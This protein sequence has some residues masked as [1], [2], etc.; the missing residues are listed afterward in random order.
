MRIPA[1]HRGTDTA[2]V[3]DELRLLGTFQLWR[4]G[5]LTTPS[6]SG[7]RVLTYLALHGAVP[8]SRV[9]GA[10]WPEVTQARANNNLRTVLWRSRGQCEQAV[11]GRGNLIW[12]DESTTVD[13]WQFER[14]ARRLLASDAS[15]GPIEPPALYLGT[16]VPDLDE[17][18]LAGHRESNRMLSV[19]ALELLAARLVA[20]GRLPA[21]LD[22]LAAVTQIDPLRESTVRLMIEIHRRQHNVVDAVLCYE[23]Y[24]AELRSELGLHPSP[25]LALLVADLSRP[26]RVLEISAGSRRSRRP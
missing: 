13:H 4:S 9:A 20:A 8:R 24:R 14:W 10:L 11:G 21:A 16:L 18:W 6:T 17:E 2:T 1:Q 5:R 12:L 22:Y 25:K 7:Q 3:R 15:A 26:G 19:Q 23:R